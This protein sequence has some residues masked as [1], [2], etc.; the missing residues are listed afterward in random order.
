MGAKPC[1]PS[2]GQAREVRST[3]GARSA[4]QACHRGPFDDPNLLRLEITEGGFIRDIPSP[5]GGQTLLTLSRL[6]DFARDCR[7]AWIRR[8]QH[9][10]TVKPVEPR[11]PYPDTGDTRTAVDP[12]TA[13]ED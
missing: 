4:V 7:L 11:R 10:L 9:H 3:I 2:D 5:D 13:Q 12:R 6:I 1:R 8:C